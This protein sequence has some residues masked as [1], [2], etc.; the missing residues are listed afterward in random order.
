MTAKYFGSCHCG[1]VKFEVDSDLEQIIEC[2]CSHCYRKGLMLTFVDPVSFRLE[3]G[4][5]NL[6]EHQFNRHAIHHQFCRTCGVQS[7]A[8][9]QRPD[10][11]KMVAVNVRTL[12]GI[13]PWS[14]KTTRVDGRSF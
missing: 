5:Q 3:S 12:E 13:E 10:G 1:A 9:G 11:A 7:F 2:N 14:L 8:H 4:E 6:T